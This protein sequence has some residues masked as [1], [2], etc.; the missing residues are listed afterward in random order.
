V[1]ETSENLAAQRADRREG[2]RYAIEGNSVLFFT[3]D[4]RA[5]AGKLVD[6]SHDGC[7]VRTSVLVQARAWFPV[8]VFFRTM[9]EAFRFSGI[10]HWASGGNLL[11]IRFVNMLPERMVA[12]AK[13]ICAVEALTQ[14]RKAAH[15]VPE[16]QAHVQSEPRAGRP[17]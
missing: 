11:G 8:E 9:G 15:L 17:L 12:L 4:G 14:A 10:V 3:G 6:L 2:P 13:V 16:Q 5:T 7:K 1:K